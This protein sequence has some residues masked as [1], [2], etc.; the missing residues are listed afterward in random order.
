MLH[1]FPVIF[2]RVRT[3]EILGEVLSGNGTLDVALNHLVLFP[4]ESQFFL[5][6][7]FPFYSILIGLPS[8]WMMRQVV[9]AA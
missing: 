4:L 5:I 9:T 8:E 3:A 2:E 1:H 7:T 6:I